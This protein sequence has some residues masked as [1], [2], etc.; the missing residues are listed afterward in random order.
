M[1]KLRLNEVRELNEAF[2][3][4]RN[5]KEIDTSGWNTENL[6]H[7]TK[8][9]YN[10]G[11]VENPQLDTSNVKY[12]DSAFEYCLGL[13]RVKNLNTSKAVS[14]SKLFANCYYLVS[15][16]ELDASSVSSSLYSYSSPIYYCYK[17]RH[18]GGLKGMRYS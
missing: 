15:V 2:V 8:A 12:L 5:V 18:F 13:K 10:T 14:L 17:L 3:D 11:F 1:P 6:G 7:L 16:D 4:C 9:F